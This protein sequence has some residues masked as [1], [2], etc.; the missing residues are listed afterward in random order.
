M[1]EVLQVIFKASARVVPDSPRGAAQET[2]AGPSRS[3]DQRSFHI[4][5]PVSAPETS[6]GASLRQRPAI[7]QRTAM[8]SMN[9]PSVGM[10]NRPA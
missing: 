9:H 3:A 8:D 5:A 6:T 1:A 7:A 2:M 4:H 10:G